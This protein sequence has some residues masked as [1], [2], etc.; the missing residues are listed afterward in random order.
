[1]R[2][3][4]F[5][6][7]TLQLYSQKNKLD[8]VYCDC[9]NARE[10]NLAAKYKINKT[11]APKGHGKKNEISS[12]KQNS[13]YTFEKEHNSSWYKLNITI[14]GT[15]TF[16]IIPNKHDDDYDFMLFKKAT[17]TIFCDSIIKYKIS[18][19][20]A[21]ISRNKDEIKGVT[22]LKNSSSQEFVK[23]GVASSFAKSI[24]VK[25]GE[26]Y[27]LVL[28]NVYENGEGH[29]IEFEINSLII[30]KGVVTDEQNIPIV[31]EIS[32]TNQKGDTVSLQKTD[33]N[34]AYNLK[35]YIN[36]FQTYNLNFY[37]DKSFSYT[38][39]F[40][41]KD[42]IELKSLNTILPLLKKGKKH[43]VG[44]INFYG[45]SSQYLPSAMPSINNLL[46]LLKKNPSLK[47]V[48]IGHSNGRGGMTKEKIIEFTK[49]RANSIK[50]YLVLNG[51]E[52]NRIE[53][54]GRGDNEMLFQLP[55]ATEKQ[56]EENRRVEISVIEY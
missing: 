33:L 32:I 44:A 55:Q 16:S 7:L 43:S 39:N 31:A 40:T 46:K 23:K 25:K 36:K 17:N 21:C 3:L 15:L 41:Y 29:S 26:I 30:I 6:F 27:Y 11:I 49:K 48:I 24:D 51:I 37:N 5:C 20:R 8:T 52:D 53:I 10:F 54:D 9:E 22:G 47:I 45:G 18:P 28:D 14:S 12:A 42:S 2:L 35:T 1:M 4:F 50:S 38:K 34:G 56:Q 19:V 13:K